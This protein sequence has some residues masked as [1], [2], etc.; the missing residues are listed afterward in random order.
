MVIAFWHQRLA[1]SDVG[2][3][4]K[5]LAGLEGGDILGG[6]AFLEELGGAGGSGE[7][8]GRGD[9][10]AGIDPLAVRRQAG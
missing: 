2:A 7:V 8:P 4:G 3:V 5:V 1:V 9:A 10:F 6:G